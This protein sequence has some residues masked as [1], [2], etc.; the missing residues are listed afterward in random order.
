[1]SAHVKTSV[2]AEIR[3]GDTIN[4]LLTEPGYPAGDGWSLSFVLINAAGAWC[5]QIASLAGVAPIGL[6]PKRRSAFTFL[7]PAGTDTAAW[8]LLLA[9][10]PGLFGL[11][12][13]HASGMEYLR[14]VGA[15]WLALGV[16]GVLLR[17]V[18]L[19]F[20]RDVQTGLVWMTKILTDPFHDIVLYHR[21]PLHLL[22]G[23]WMD[24]GHRPR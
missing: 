21:A 13:P 19:F 15:G 9:A 18:H 5:D 16:G 20:I 6:V 2:P 7:P 24:P 3:A 12:E 1:M 17:T 22:R 10:A 11:F 4:W 14:Q 23:E 8:P